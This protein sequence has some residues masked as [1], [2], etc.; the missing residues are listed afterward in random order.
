MLIHLNGQLIPRSQARIDPFDRGFIFG[1]GVYEG[2]RSIP[3]SAGVPRDSVAGSAATRIIGLQ[4][5]IRRMQRGLEASGVPFDLSNLGKLSADLCAANNLTDAF[6]YWQVTGGNPGEG[7]PLRSRARGKNTTPTIFGY[8]APQPPLTN[9]STPPLKRAT[10]L[11]DIRWEY[12]WLKSTSLMGNVICAHQADQ[13]HC[14][15]AVFTRNGFITEGL[16]TNLVL[17]LP[18]ESPERKLRSLSSD[19]LS[20]AD[21][22][23]VTPSLD[24]GPM[25]SGITRQILLKVEPRLRERPVRVEELE[26]AKEIMFLGTIT[27]VAS[28]IE[29]N[30]RK[31]GD[32]TPGPHARALLK[33]LV[34]AIQTGKDIE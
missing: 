4:Q 18:K 30:G 24:S 6:V 12:G 14:D 9:Q 23:L 29:L 1:E 7:D 28:A 2:L 26:H 8:C 34:A 13:Q 32:G 31:I 27:T 3:S 5:H 16:A 25:L 11:R 21:Y 33:T 15:E 22:E 17:V 19:Q 10:V 20:D